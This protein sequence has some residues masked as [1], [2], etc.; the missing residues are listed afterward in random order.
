MTARSFAHGALLATALWFTLWLTL[1]TSTPPDS[2]IDNSAGTS[3]CESTAPT[4]QED[5]LSNETEPPI[6]G[7]SAAAP[8]VQF[9]IGLLS[10]IDK[11][12][13]Q[14]NDRGVFSRHLNYSAALAGFMHHAAQL[15]HEAVTSQS[16]NNSRCFEFLRPR[17]ETPM[18][19]SQFDTPCVEWNTPGLASVFSNPLGVVAT[20]V[21]GDGNSSSGLRV[22]VTM[23]GRVPTEGL[24]AVAATIRK[25]L[26]EPMNALLFVATCPGGGDAVRGNA[27]GVTLSSLREAYGTKHLAAVQ[28]VDVPTARAVVVTAFPT[29]AV[30][31]SHAIL[32]HRIL[33]VEAVNNLTRVY[34]NSNASFSRR[35]VLHHSRGTT[36]PFDVIVLVKPGMRLMGALSFFS[37]HEL[38]FGTIAMK[39]SCGK[40]E[41]TA[42]FNDSVVLVAPR[43]A[44]P[45]DISVVATRNG[46]DTFASLFTIAAGYP[47]SAQAKRF[48]HVGQTLPKLWQDHAK[49]LKL[50]LADAQGAGWVVETTAANSQHFATDDLGSYCPKTIVY[51]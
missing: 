39:F 42:I 41:S 11:L 34:T 7:G 29:L 16:P 31:T 8:V 2:L 25:A 40:H 4:R 1:G 47:L 5:P 48:F 12:I 17:S 14:W 45:S 22:G 18:D 37:H 10:A 28:L 26:L 3:T 23:A 13:S 35:V 43:T 32:M 38:L 9:P 24:S 6:S 15:R 51:F 44:P 50:V 27:S 21:H 49:M 19:D 33:M 36:T 20:F 30:I 46:M